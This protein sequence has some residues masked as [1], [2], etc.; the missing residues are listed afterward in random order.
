MAE[1]LPYLGFRVVV[2]L[3]AVPSA[4]SADVCSAEV[5][6]QEHRSAA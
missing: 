3:G 2:R 1:F 5:L 6:L 4:S